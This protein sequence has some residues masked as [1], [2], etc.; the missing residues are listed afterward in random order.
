MTNAQWN[1]FKGVCG[2][3]HVPENGHGDPGAIDI[4]SIMALAGGEASTPSSPD[5][6]SEDEVP[7]ILEESNPTDVELEPGV[8]T[9]LAFKGDGILY[10]GPVKHSTVVT[11]YFDTAIDAETK[12]QGRF[13]LTDVTDLKNEHPSAYLVIDHKG[14]GGHQFVHSQSVPA[15]KRLWF[16]VRSVD[17]TAKLLHRA[18]SGPYWV[19]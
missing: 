14:G 12:I 16:Q 4:E 7:S 3:M 5:A 19:G 15:G 11:L 13:F 2:H 17:V 8:W 6:Q 1:S 10:A 9:T 18:A